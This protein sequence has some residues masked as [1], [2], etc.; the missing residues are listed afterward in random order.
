MAAIKPLDQASEKWV[1][2]AGVAGVDYA[3]G[4]AAPRRS[5]SDGAK[6]GNANWKAGMTAAA[7]RDAFVK[8][9]DKAGDTRWKEMAS[10]KGPGRFAEGVAIGKED[11]SKGFSPY[12]SAIS[13]IKLGDR[14]PRGSMQNYERSKAIGVALRTLKEKAG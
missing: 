12:H 6:A 1:R 4:I 10:K 7:G 9:V 8:G 14:G 13:A 2:R 5:W 11:W 3:N